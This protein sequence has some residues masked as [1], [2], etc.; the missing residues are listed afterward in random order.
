MVKDTK[1]GDQIFFWNANRTKMAHT[2]LVVKVDDTKVYTVEGNTSRSKGVVPNGGGVWEKEY[3][4]TY[5]RIRDYGRPPYDEEP[6]KEEIP[7]L[8]VDNA[9]T[10]KVKSGDSLWGIA[11]NKLGDGRRYTE[12]MKLNK[13]TSTVLRVGMILE[14][15]VNESP[16]PA[17]KKGDTVKVKQGAKTYEGKKLA[18][19]VYKRKHKVKE[20]SSDRAVIT[21]AGVTV[22]A[23]HTADLTIA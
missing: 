21:Y 2:G 7:E 11:A 20:V 6:V 13:L 3:K 15:P 4:L 5:K 18:S 1:P 10:Y 23:V 22:A 16:T 14:L 8:E 19:F 17:I 12:I 9:T